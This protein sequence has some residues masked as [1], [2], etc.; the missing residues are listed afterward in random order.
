MKERE[1]IEMISSK[2]FKEDPLA[3][4]FSRVARS[5]CAYKKKK[6]EKGR[7]LKDVKRITSEAGLNQ[8]Q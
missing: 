4:S 8:F 3:Q 6:L 7:V 2:P 1:S 5:I